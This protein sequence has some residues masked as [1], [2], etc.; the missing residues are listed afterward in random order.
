MG[1]HVLPAKR[2]ASQMACLAVE[3][4]EAIP[5]GVKEPKDPFTIFVKGKHTWVRERNG[6]RHVF[7]DSSMF[8]VKRIQALPS[9]NPK[10]SLAILTAPLDILAAETGLVS[11]VV[12]KARV[13]AGGRVEPVQTVCGR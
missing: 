7:G 12:A 4:R 9:S 8:S 6:Q 2:V 5:R 3:H 10:R 1:R 13:R 11:I